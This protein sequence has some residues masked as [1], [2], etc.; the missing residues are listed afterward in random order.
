MV[1]MR[2]ADK[3]CDE[4]GQLLYGQHNQSD[5]QQLQILLHLLQLL[6]SLFVFLQLDM[7]TQKCKILERMY[8]AILSYSGILPNHAS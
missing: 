7:S 3:C 1:G 4:L 8:R 6:L 2:S 5:H